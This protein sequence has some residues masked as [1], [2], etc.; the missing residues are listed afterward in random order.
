LIYTT[1]QLGEK[2]SLTPEGYLL[3]QDVPIARLGT[4]PYRRFELSEPDIVAGPDGRVIVE[5]TPEEVFK[6]EAIASFEGKP[7]TIEHPTEAEVTPET[8]TKYA[9]GTIQNVRQGEG[10]QQ[11]L[12]LADLLVTD[13]EA[14]ELIQDG[15]RE[16]SCG[17]NSKIVP[18][19]PGRARATQIIGNHLAL[20][21]E[22]RCGSQCSIGDSAINMMKNLKSRIIDALTKIMDEAPEDEKPEEKPVTDEA[23]TEDPEDQPITDEDAPLTLESLCAR[24]DALEAALA[25][26][27][28]VNDAAPE[29]DKKEDKPEDK[30]VN[31]EASK[32]DEKK[33]KVTDSA[34]I[35]ARAE[36]LAPGIQFPVLDSKASTKMINDSM[37]ALKRKA[38]SSAL[39]DSKTRDAVL[40]LLDGVDINK[41]PCAALHQTFVGASEL[42]K[43]HNNASAFST[44]T[45][46]AIPTLSI[47]DINKSFWARQ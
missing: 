28:P 14:I 26:L 15:L 17:Y 16:V 27:K 37:C 41:L 4:Q 9:K 3:I 36:I 30:P 10:D 22:G 2:I 23:P 20:V 46:S 44:V 34:S 25:A 38:L 40:P 12:L 6:P 42:V 43:R 18:L 47:N 33:D 39:N 1:V 24:I 7:I 45:D 11:D 21:E 5:R 8:W 32:E 29:G 31:D 35:F 19:S 13:R